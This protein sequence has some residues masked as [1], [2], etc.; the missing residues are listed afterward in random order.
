MDTIADLMAT[1]DRVRN[2][3]RWGDDDQLGTLNYITEAKVAEASR[4]V[5]TGR[6]FP[7]GVEFG[8]TG[9]QGDLLYRGNPIHMMTVTGGRAEDL[10]EYAKD[11]DT[12]PKAQQ[13]A[14]TFATGPMRF[15]DDVI[16]MPLQAASQW[17]ALSHVY[18]DDRLYNGFPASSVT[19]VGAARCSIDA[20]VEKGI[21]SRGVLLDVVRH[22]GGGSAIGP[23]P[24]VTPEELERIAETQGVS[25][26]PGDILVVHTGWW[27]EWRR[28]GQRRP[29]VAGLNWR[30]AE[31]FHDKQ[32]AAVAGDSMTVEHAVQ[33]EVEGVVLPMHLLCIRDM[34]M[35]L[36][37]Y[38]DTSALAADCAADGRYAFQ[39]VA[40]PL[41]ITGAVGSPVNPIAIK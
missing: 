30:C 37:E 29:P 19:S 16:I 24:S 23:E 38:W 39:L 36:G 25:I 1:A 32:V 41:K 31:W 13:I 5:R 40:P 35:M 26:E 14:R 11:W 6:I 20:V 7:L 22:R 34:G 27:S 3:G 10:I 9:P 33:P 2:W 4:L 12:N 21:V 15:N 8:S 18:Y 28:T 17:D